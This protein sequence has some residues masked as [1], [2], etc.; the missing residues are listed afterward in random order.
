MRYIEKLR[1]IDFRSYKHLDAP[2]T[3][4][5]VVLFGANGAG[6]TNLL[7]AIS[8]LSPGRGL[9]RAKVDEVTRRDNGAAAPA[10][11]VTAQLGGLDIPVKLAVGQLP[12]YPRRR[13][14]RI[15]DKAASGTELAHYMTMMWLTP[16]QD[17]LFVGPSSDRRKFLDRFT[18]VHTP[19]HGFASLRYEKLRSER[20]RLLSEGVN[21]AFWY[22]ALETDMAEHGA[23][24]AM[25]R[26]KTVNL[27]IAEL[28][29]WPDSA[30]PR[31]S[32]ALDG[33]AEIHAQNGWD[34]T[35]INQ[36]ICQSL[37]DGRG[38]DMRAGRTLSGVHRSDFKITHV[39]KNMPAADCSTGEQKAL[40][41]SLILAHAR[42]QAEQSPI[43][44][45]DEV[46]A[47][48][49]RDRRAALIEHLLALGTQLF[50]TGT[51]ASL[52]EA[53][54]GRAQIFEVKDHALHRQD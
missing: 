41:I 30:F 40:L 52:F 45:L 48:L 14:I 42:A 16:A 19:S 53:F 39:D 10:W 20:N 15:D 49:D 37:S 34:E 24:I 44:L 50:M 36:F 33:A 7:E 31:A 54:A 6:K 9:R 5:P 29:D 21:D 13:H 51:D 32:L 38:L 18:L 11:G 26:A 46:A 47:H 23:K 25:A 3:A 28:S 8:F 22:D 1:L 12:E 4:A 17:R 43:L 2:L 27:L 35:E